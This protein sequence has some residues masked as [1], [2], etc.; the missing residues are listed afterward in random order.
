MAK[1]VD[2]DESSE[3]E[4]E[5]K[6]TEQ[7]QEP[8]KNIEPVNNSIE[9]I[10][11]MVQPLNI[12]MSNDQNDNPVVF[13]LSNHSKLSTTNLVNEETNLMEKPN[14]EESSFFCVYDFVNMMTTFVNFHFIKLFIIAQDQF[15][16]SIFPVF[17]FVNCTRKERIVQI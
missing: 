15:F 4:E 12:A 9:V 6:E 5:K 13:N 7:I 17:N 16:V 10:T 11:E 1:V 8:P 3:A 14:I 2:D